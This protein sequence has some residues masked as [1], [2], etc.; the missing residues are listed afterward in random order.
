[1]EFVR[2]PDEQ[3]NYLAGGWLTMGQILSVPMILIGIYLLIRTHQ[4]PVPSGNLSAVVQ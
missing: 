1:V 4:R 3:L 2:V